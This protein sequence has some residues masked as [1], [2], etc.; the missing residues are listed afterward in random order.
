MLI[1]KDESEVMLRATIETSRRVVA[2]ARARARARVRGR[3]RV[4]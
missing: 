2:T 3:A 1:V 4:R